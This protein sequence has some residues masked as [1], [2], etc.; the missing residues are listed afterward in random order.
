MPVEE[1][2]FK[3]RGPFG[4]KFSKVSL[5]ANIILEIEEFCNKIP[6]PY[7]MGVDSREADF[8]TSR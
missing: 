8:L 7:P 6:S 2:G 3:F 5:F 4:I 1:H